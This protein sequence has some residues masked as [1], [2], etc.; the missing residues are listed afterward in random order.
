[1]PELTTLVLT[2]RALAPVDHT[3][4]R[5]GGADT[6]GAYTMRES[7]DVPANS[8]NVRLSHRRTSNG[9]FITQM[10]AE[11]PVVATETVNGVDNS[12]LLRTAFCQM[13]FTFSKDSTSQERKDVIGM[14]QSALDATDPLSLAAVQT[15]GF[16]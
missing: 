8:S 11:F 7:A 16:Y 12:K 13:K 6:N 3:F 1:M 9:N 10:N 2:D 14:I 4:S 5:S 15:E